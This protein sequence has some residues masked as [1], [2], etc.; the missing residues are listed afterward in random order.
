M[1]LDCVQWLAITK[2]QEDEGQ[3]DEEHLILAQLFFIVKLLHEYQREATFQ[4]LLLRLAPSS[5]TSTSAAP[6]EPIESM[7]L[8]PLQL[9][10]QAASDDASPQDHHR[11]AVQVHTPERVGSMLVDGVPRGDSGYRLEEVLLGGRLR[12]RT[13]ERR[14]D[15]MVHSTVFGVLLL[16]FLNLNL[17]SRHLLTVLWHTQID[18][19]VLVVGESAQNAGKELW[20]SAEYVSKQLHRLKNG[21]CAFVSFLAVSQGV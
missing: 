14:A 20:Y 8:A 3:M 11:G 17:S 16:P 1:P 12:H 13:L 9:D 5:S 21:S 2:L 18:K 19:A 7:Q 15:L 10:A 4:F 6:L